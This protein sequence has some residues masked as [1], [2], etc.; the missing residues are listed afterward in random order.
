M[1]RWPEADLPLFRQERVNDP[2]AALKLLA[3][4]ARGCTRCD[5]CRNATQTVFGEGPADASL[6]LVGEQP[7]D[8]EDLVGR[9]FI[10]P[11][12]KVLDKA[13][14]VAGIERTDVYVT[15]AVKH[16]K[17]EPRG[18]RRIHKKPDTSE[19]EACR[20]W[21]GNE[22]DIVQPRVVVALG[23]TAAR[24]LMHKALSI[25]ANRGRLI[26]LEGEMKAVITV[27]PS[28]L[29]R[30]REERDK[31]REFDLLVKDLRL[32]ADAASRS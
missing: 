4:E 29:L 32:A 23:A 28:Y 2:E 14:E 8:Q 17:N 22:L 6:V 19:I 12:G 31:R 26:A 10:G 9:P 21:L 7:G 1:A 16:F 27:H 11:A 20:F 15:N 3:A 13:L 18:K 30:L 24:A 5:L 25:N